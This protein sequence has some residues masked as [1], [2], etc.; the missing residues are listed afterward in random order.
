VYW[1]GGGGYIRPNSVEFFLM[2]QRSVWD[3]GLLTVEASQS[4]SDTPLSVWL[5]YTSDWPVAETSL[6]DNTQH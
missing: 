5:I 1:G 2:T 3:L 4:H 6:H